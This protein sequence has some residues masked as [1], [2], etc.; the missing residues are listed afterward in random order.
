MTFNAP[1]QNFCSLRV[2][3]PALLAAAFLVAP[4]AGHCAGE[5]SQSARA[6]GSSDCAQGMGCAKPAKLGKNGQPEGM[7]DSK[8]SKL[9]GNGMAEGMGDGKSARQLRTYEKQGQSGMAT[10]KETPM[11]AMRGQAQPPKLKP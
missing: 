9:G 11:Q 4:V 10:M 6:G 1:T 8:P 3:L 5:K 2:L 7:S